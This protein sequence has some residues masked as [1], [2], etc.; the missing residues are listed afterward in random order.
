MPLDAVRDLAAVEERINK[1][2]D[3]VRIAFWD[4]AVR[5]RM[6]R[7][8]DPDVKKNFRILLES[9]HLSATGPLL[10]ERVQGF[11]YAA[12]EPALIKFRRVHEF[13]LV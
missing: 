7:N 11:G 1:R 8:P 9:I 6:S 12:P 2:E 10:P 13:H 4:S 3:R 5:E